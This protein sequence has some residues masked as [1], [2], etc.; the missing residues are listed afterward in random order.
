MKATQSEAEFQRQVTAMANLL[1]WRVAS[2]RAVAVKRANGQVYHETPVGADGRG[3]PDLVLVHR[4]GRII[5]AELKSD[6]GKLRPEQ[7]VWLEWLGRTPAAA[8]VWRPADIDTIEAV[9]RTTGA[10]TA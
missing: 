2:F 8:C 4:D 1:G 5:F 7:K 9:L 3:W 10:V 6:G